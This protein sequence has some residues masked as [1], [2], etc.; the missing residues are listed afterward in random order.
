MPTEKCI[1]MT[2]KRPAAKRPQN[3]DVDGNSIKFHQSVKPR[4]SQKS[5][6]LRAII[7]LFT[8]SESHRCTIVLIKVMD[9][10]ICNGKTNY[11][12]SIC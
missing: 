10:E 3:L 4:G 9:I 7:T 8:R 2:T 11:W 5:R 1:V 6:Y 12:H